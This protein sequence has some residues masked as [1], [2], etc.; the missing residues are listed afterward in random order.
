MVSIGNMR[1]YL[2]AAA[3]IV[4]LGIKGC[5]SW[6]TYG[7]NDALTWEADFDKI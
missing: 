6:N 7:T 4:S 1:P 3:V 2:L 5:L